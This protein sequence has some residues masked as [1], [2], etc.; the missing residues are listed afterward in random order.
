MSYNVTEDIIRGCSV[1]SQSSISKDHFGGLIFAHPSRWSDTHFILTHYSL[2]LGCFNSYMCHWPGDPV[3]TFHSTLRTRYTFL[4]DT[5]PCIL[6]AVLSASYLR[7]A[8]LSAFPSLLLIPLFIQYLQTR[9]LRVLL[10]GAATG[11]CRALW[12]R[13][14]V[15]HTSCTHRTSW[16]EF[17][18]HSPVCPHQPM[19]HIAAH[20][21][22]SRPSLQRFYSFPFLR[23]EPLSSSAWQRRPFQVYPPWNASPIVCPF[24]VQAA[25]THRG[26]PNP[27]TPLRCQ[28]RGLLRP[29]P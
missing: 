15:A 21:T 24:I 20:L 14:R 29:W 16:L 12:K 18:F 4:M 9:K 1:P 19:K 25:L 17:D 7:V 11:P 10:D 23:E 28:R 3:L 2:V 8:P 27:L 26:S 5:F 22:L 13:E 6:H